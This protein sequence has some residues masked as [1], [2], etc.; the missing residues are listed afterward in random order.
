MFNYLVLSYLSLSYEAEVK[1]VRQGSA[2]QIYYISNEPYALYILC[3][4]IVQFD[5]HIFGTVPT[6][7][8]CVE[9]LT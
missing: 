1:Y 7:K 3:I 2:L 9:K 8:V 5:Q 4:Y 6:T